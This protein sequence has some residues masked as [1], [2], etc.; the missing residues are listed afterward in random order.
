MTDIIAYAISCEMFCTTHGAELE[1]DIIAANPEA[2]EHDDMEVYPVMSWQSDELDAVEFCTAGH[3]F[4]G[5]CGSDMDMTRGSQDADFNGHFARCWNCHDES[6]YV[7]GL[8]RSWVGRWTSALDT[9]TAQ[10]YG[11]TVTY[12]TDLNGYT[13]VSAVL[14]E[15]TGVMHRMKAFIAYMDCNPGAG[16]TLVL[17][18]SWEDAFSAACDELIDESEPIPHEPADVDVIAVDSSQVWFTTKN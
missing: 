1:A 18:D 17:A 16:V 11:I 5:S 6:V 9:H 15:S 13:S 2:D 10:V 4:C 7:D 8:G 3:A 14:D 12:Q